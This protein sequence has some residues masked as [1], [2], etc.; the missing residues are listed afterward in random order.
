[1]LGS[2]PNLGIISARAEIFRFTPHVGYRARKIDHA[3]IF[4]GCLH[5]ST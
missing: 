5:L 4:R 3:A 1:M 2:E